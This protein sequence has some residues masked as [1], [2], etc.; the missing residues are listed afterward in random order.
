MADMLVKLYA[1]PELA[2][3]LTPL[4]ALGVEIRP[5]LA[6]ERRLLGRWARERFSETIAAS[7]EAAIDQRPITCLLA[8]ERR[9][10][11]PAPS[12]EQPP[13][14]LL[15]GAC[16]DVAAL[17]LF[18][19]VAVSQERRRAGIGRALLLASLHAMKAQGYAYA[20]IG[21][22]GEPE[23]YANSVGAI[24]IPGS[25]PGIYRGPLDID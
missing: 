18:G 11:R 24:P 13:E 15:G 20:V 4:A 6:T 23:F 10:L 12:Y 19:P 17:G 7:F 25:E 2:P 22:A 5:A 1:L 14:R 21:W 8:V 3:V 16:H 9:P